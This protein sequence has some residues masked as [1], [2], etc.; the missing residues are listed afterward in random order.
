MTP[1]EIPGG[2]TVSAENCAD[3]PLI[4]G[5]DGV[6]YSVW[7]LSDEERARVAAGDPVVLG[8]WADKTP[9]VFVGVGVEKIPAAVNQ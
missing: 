8:V 5:A 7:K 2:F 9:P 6:L 1:V 3:L 4:R